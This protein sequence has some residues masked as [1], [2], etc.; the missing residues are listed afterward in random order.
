M[1]LLTALPLIKPVLNWV[2]T[3]V[4]LNRAHDVAIFTKLNDML[5]ESSF[6]NILNHNLYNGY[7]RR[8]ENTF[9]QNFVESLRRIENRYL[10]AVVRLRAEELAWA[11]DQLLDIV[12]QTFFP[13]R[14]TE[15]GRA[16]CRERVCT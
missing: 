15:I 16:S 2:K 13:L 3:R 11:M 4:G 8:E 5:D 6:D 14:E 1:D 12:V 10:E 7:L 9:L